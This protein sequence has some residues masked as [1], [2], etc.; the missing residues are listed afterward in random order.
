MDNYYDNN[1]EQN[2]NRGPAE[3]TAA[4]NKMATAALVL[5]I[6]SVIS[7]QIFFIALPLAGASIILALLSRG[8]GQMIPRAKIALIAGLI[9]AVLS[10]GVTYYAVRTVMTD[11]E[12]REQFNTMY[13]Y[14]MGSGDTDIS[15]D[16]SDTTDP[17]ALI[18]S[19][20]SGDYRKSGSSSSDSSSSSADGS[21]SS[22]SASS[23]GSQDSS[24]GGSS[25]LVSGD[26]RNG[27]SFI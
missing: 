13:N 14:Y 2:F 1:N 8:R 3:N 6:I 11:P 9:S 27:G 7:F 16:S 17:N 12:L 26:G 10:C 25:S 19:I 21:T 15:S 20:I 22:G 5:A 23:G 24:L 4:G 18:E